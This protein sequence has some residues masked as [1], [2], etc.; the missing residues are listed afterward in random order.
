MNEY[1]AVLVQAALEEQAAGRV[2][3]AIALLKLV[4]GASGADGYVLYALGRFQYD[5]RCF[6]AAEAALSVSVRIDP[7]H[8][9]AF[10]DLGAV[11]FALNRDAEALVY[12]R[13]A[14]ELQPDL[15]ESAESDSMWALRYGQ[16]REGWKR[17]EARYRTL[18]SAKFRRDFAEPRWTGEPAQGRTILLHAE[19]GIGDTIQFLRYAPLVAARG[20]RVVLEVHRGLR[21]LTGALPGV[22]D[23]VELGDPLPPFD[24]QCPMLSLPMVFDTDLDSIPATIPYL[25]V[26]SERIYQW[27][28]R[29]GPRRAKRIGI[30]WS[31]NPLH[32]ED[33]RRSIALARFARVLAPHPD[34]EFHVLQADVRESDRAALAGLPHVR[35]HSGMLRDFAD[36]AALVSLMDLVISVDT[37]VA[38]LAGALGWPVWLLLAAVADWR[39]LLE[40]D[41][42]PW[43]PTV[44]LFRQ[45]EAGGWDPV[46]DAVLRQMQEMLG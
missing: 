30:A 27:R 23:V 21:A 25:S 7:G 2:E 43:Y 33:A 34:R 20:A 40:R 46:L 37:S 38:H 31:G 11:L 35:D 29:L 14:L 18:E 1:A 44:W 5:A 10:N 28:T 4:V 8:A 19:Q 39:W 22:A 6:A 24:L 3:P 26:P 15:A 41:D 45:T 13:R 36:T 42:S 12:I 17:Y 9:A 16:F 32:R